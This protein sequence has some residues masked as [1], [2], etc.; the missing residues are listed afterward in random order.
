MFRRLSGALVRSALI[1]GAW[2]VCH[3]AAPVTAQATLPS[4]REIV[5]RHLE[6]MGGEA[7]FKA[8]QSMHARGSLALT[9]QQ[10][11]GQID[12]FSARPNKQL[13]RAT[14]TGIGP[15]E[16]GYDGTVGWSIDPVTGATLMTGR[17][18]LEMSDD[19]VFDGPLYPASH[20]KDLSVIGREAFDGRQAYR[21]KVTFVSGSEQFELFDAESKLHIGTEARRE[22]PLG[23]VPMTTLA[24]EYKQFGALRL[25]TVLV[26]KA[27]GFEQVVTL[28]SY[29]FNG[30]PPE[31]F[32]IPARIKALIKSPGQPGR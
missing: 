23:V 3:Q 22:T 10:I 11:G 16:T 30:V 18:L 4:G 15:T 20:V 8:V 27:L 17:Q 13:V 31:T 19:A 14:I 6:A 5:A 26:Q 24:R 28:A 29:E 32:A 9:A 2:L 7:A 25:P 12:V 1:A 21:V